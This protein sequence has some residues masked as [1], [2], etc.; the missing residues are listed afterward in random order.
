MKK[1]LMAATFAALA[2]AGCGGA[3]EPDAAEL[4]VPGQPVYQN[5]PRNAAELAAMETP[6]PVPGE[7]APAAPQIISLFDGKESSEIVAELSSVLKSFHA[8]MQRIPD[9]LEELVTFGFLD[10]LP[11]APEGA[12]YVIVRDSLDVSLKTL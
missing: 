2:F 10:V 5:Q 8:E 12:Q 3:P 11:G 9:T 6:P 1:E 4:G 7:P